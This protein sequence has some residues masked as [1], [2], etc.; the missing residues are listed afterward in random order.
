M[1]Y[2]RIGFGLSQSKRLDKFPSLPSLGWLWV[3][4]V[5]FPSALSAPLGLL[6][7]LFWIVG[8]ESIAR[9]G[10]PPLTTK[11]TFVEKHVGRVGGYVA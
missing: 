7:Y 10:A 9:E 4:G 11:P 6:G 2:A 3:L 1:M 8:P 5:P